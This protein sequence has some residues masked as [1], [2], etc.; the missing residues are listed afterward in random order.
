MIKSIDR[1][2]CG[3]V[4]AAEIDADNKRRPPIGFK[5]LVQDKKAREAATPM[6]VV[7]MDPAAVDKL[8]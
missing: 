7:R 4:K 5:P 1:R 2:S 6:K 3:L 8:L